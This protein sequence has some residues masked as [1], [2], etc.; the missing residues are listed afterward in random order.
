MRV[1]CSAR[2]GQGFSLQVWDDAMQAACKPDCRMCTTLIEVCTR[3]GLTERA[4]STY[5][6]MQNAPHN[7]N[8][9]PTV[10]AYT[11]AMRAAAEGGKWQTAL[12]IW[13]DLRIAG[14]PASGKPKNKAFP[15][16]EYPSAIQLVSLRAF[17]LSSL[18]AVIFSSLL[19]LM[20]NFLHTSA[21]PTYDR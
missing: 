4:L 9:T 21:S 2:G 7:S 11:A 5:E 6:M 17:L 14:C 15:L 20:R 3:K 19:L 8:L 1:L 10:H 18:H 16:P 13:N 12:Q